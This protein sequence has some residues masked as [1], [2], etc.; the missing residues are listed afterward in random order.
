MN[1]IVEQINVL[2]PVTY[3]T[4]ILTGIQGPTLAE[5]YE[6]NG[7]PISRCQPWQGW[8]TDGLM[9]QHYFARGEFRHEGCKKILGRNVIGGHTFEDASEPTWFIGGIEKAVT[10]SYFPFLPRDA[11]AFEIPA[12][13]IEK[14]IQSLWIQNVKLSLKLKAD[15]PKQVISEIKRAEKSTL[16]HCCRGAETAFL[17]VS[18]DRSVFEEIKR[19]PDPIIIGWGWD[20]KWHVVA[21]WN[22][23]LDLSAIAQVP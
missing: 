15:L 10:V 23:D 18:Y 9:E 5:V 3:E 17:A 20:N 19:K 4:T 21:A 7:W 16:F 22:I 1:K 2:E 6:L 12:D 11:M 14:A 8:S 13:K